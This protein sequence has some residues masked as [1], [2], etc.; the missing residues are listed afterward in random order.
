MLPNQ[1]PIVTALENSLWSLRATDLQNIMHSNEITIHQNISYK[2]LALSEIIRPELAKI[3]SQNGSFVINLKMSNSTLKILIEYLKIMTE[4]IENHTAVWKIS[5]KLV[6]FLVEHK[7]STT[8]KDLQGLVE[9]ARGFEFTPL[10]KA[11]ALFEKNTLGQS[12]WKIKSLTDPHEILGINSSKN[13][14]YKVLALSPV[15]KSMMDKSYAIDSPSVLLLQVDAN[16]LE[17]FAKYLLLIAEKMEQNRSICSIAESLVQSL[18]DDSFANKDACWSFIAVVKICD[19]A[20]LW[21]AFNLS[22]LQ[23]DINKETVKL[24]KINK[25]LSEQEKELEALLERI[26]N[27]KKMVENSEGTIRK[28]KVE[29]QEKVNKERQKYALADKQRLQAINAIVGSTK[30]VKA[31]PRLAEGSKEM[32]EMTQPPKE[33]TPDVAYMPNVDQL[34]ITPDTPSLPFT[35]FLVDLDEPKQDDSRRKRKRT[36]SFESD[37]PKRSKHQFPCDHCSSRFATEKDLE[38]HMNLLHFYASNEMGGIT[39]PYNSSW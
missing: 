27:S 36:Q 16:G 17:L 39:D 19:F 2:A 15:L 4:E 38:E 1:K 14:P 34:E 8:L 3:Y 37:T 12:F 31:D 33:I 23:F 10:I 25:E 5:W 28:L 22:G 7:Y 26:S 32:P 13:I 11:F 6:P 35:P 29:L 18:I 24:S 21:H 20:L 30:G 9:A